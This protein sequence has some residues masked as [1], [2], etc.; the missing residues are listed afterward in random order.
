MLPIKKI[1]I[2]LVDDHRVLREALRALLTTEPD[3]EVVGEAEDGWQAVEMA[4]KLQPD[5][6]VMD[7]AMPQLN[8]LDATRRLIKEAPRTKVLIL[9]S[10]SD[11]K[12]VQELGEAGAVGYFLKQTGAPEFIKALREASKGKTSFSSSIIAKRRIEQGRRGSS[13]EGNSGSA[14]SPVPLTSREREVI[15]MVA[16][17]KGNR[18]AA[19]ELGV[20][21]KT[22]EKHRQHAMNKLNIHDIAG[23]TRYAVAEGIVDQMTG[24]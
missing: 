5:V 1:T 18:Q 15:Q 12:F 14:K 2:L 4:G 23:L 6:V 13:S 17:G 20:S 16:E 19:A 8:G 10:Y 21:I 9:S 3:L 24:L 22:V 7:I 11:E